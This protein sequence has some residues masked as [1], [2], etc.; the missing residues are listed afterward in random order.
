MTGRVPVDGVVVT[1]FVAAAL[2]L[3]ARG[4]LADHPQHD[5]WAPLDLN[6]PPGWAT[7][8]KLAALRSDP[9]ECRAVLE[10]SGVAFTALPPAGEGACLREDRTV[11]ADAPLAPDAPPAT[12][13]VGAALVLWLRQG[14]QPAAEE[15]PNTTRRTPITCISTRPRGASAGFAGDKCC[16]IP[17]PVETADLAARIL[18]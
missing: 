11:L 2:F 16:S 6:D 1:L 7:Q 17:E 3:A 12:C 18:L 15:R 8:R 9:A 13:A 10:R 4:W 5:P 14:V